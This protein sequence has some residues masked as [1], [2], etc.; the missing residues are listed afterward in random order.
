VTKTCATILRRCAWWCAALACAGPA[1]A[2]AP[3]EAPE[4][5]K[6]RQLWSESPHGRMLQRILPPAIRPNEL[7]EAES[8]GA[9]LTVRY[10]VQCH[11]LPN[12]HM[13]TADR[14][15]GIVERMVWRMQGKGNLGTLM[16]D[17]MAGIAAPSR[18]E[19]AILDRYL[20]KY[21]Q[22]AIDPRHPGLRTEAG[23]M[24]SLACSQCHAAPDPR[25]HAPSEWPAIVARMKEHMAWANVVVGVDELR[26]EPELKTE[27]I[28][29]FLQ[30]YANASGIEVK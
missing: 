18:E 12:P 16:K 6:A 24:F 3:P 27:A 22:Q 15:S 5:A 8:E 13:H 14:W 30:R 26:T 9:K 20:R 2:A 25:Q 19:V 17:M 11:Y 7:P 28:V 21:S 1:F 10:C 29:R 23:R 4:I